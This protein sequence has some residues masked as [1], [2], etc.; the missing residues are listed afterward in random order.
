MTDT[1]SVIDLFRSIETNRYGDF[2]IIYK[3]FIRR[4]REQIGEFFIAETKD[5]T[6][7]LCADFE[8]YI[9]K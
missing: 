1:K 8:K 7:Q 2:E 3:A 5:I 6:Q 4:N 9:L